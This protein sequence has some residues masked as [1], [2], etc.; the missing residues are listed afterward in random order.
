MR[1]LLPI[2]VALATAFAFAAAAAA[3]AAAGKTKGPKASAPPVRFGVLTKA[4]VTRAVLLHPAESVRN[5]VVTAIAARDPKE[6]ANMASFAKHHH[7]A[8]M[9]VFD[10]YEKLIND[11]RV[12]A[13]Y[14]PLPT[15]L[16]YTWAMKAM[17]AG[18]HVLVEKP[19]ASN[20][21]EAR[22]MVA[23]AKEQRVVLME[24]M[25]PFRHRFFARARYLL[26]T[27]TIGTVTHIEA[28]F[29]VPK[30]VPTRCARATGRHSMATS[31]VPGPADTRRC[32]LLHCRPCA[33]WPGPAR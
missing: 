29:N 15:G 23:F 5:A 14:I 20:A 33:R 11:P 30:Q 10:T 2:A 17:R 4:G 13:V 21:G 26:R 12:D 31:P 6:A 7:G 19:F 3:A 27:G 24:A 25:H 9:E 22:R 18:K 16:H 28:H 1:G 32:G 8:D